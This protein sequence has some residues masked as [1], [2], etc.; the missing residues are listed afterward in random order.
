MGNL[1][2]N[3][4]VVI[5]EM[6]CSWWPVLDAS[7]KPPRAWESPGGGRREG[8]ACGGAGRS[9]AGALVPTVG[10]TLEQTELPFLHQLPYVSHVGHLLGWERPGELSQPRLCLQSVLPCRRSPPSSPP[11]VLLFPPL[12][13]FISLRHPGLSLLE[14]YSHKSSLSSNYLNGGKGGEIHL[15]STSLWD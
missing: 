9:W 14:N 11:F 15:E 4:T 1:C 3:L 12:F 8:G 7:L 13:K 10:N 6:L 5:A 2:C